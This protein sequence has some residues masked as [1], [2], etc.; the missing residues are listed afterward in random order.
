MILIV[1]FEKKIVDKPR[2]HSKMNHVPYFYSFSL[3]FLKQRQGRKLFFEKCK[4][5]VKMQI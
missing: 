3:M 5:K 1:V 2:E 4:I